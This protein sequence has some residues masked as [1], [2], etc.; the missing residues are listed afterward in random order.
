MAENSSITG[1]IISLNFPGINSEVK[2]AAPKERGNAITIATIVTLTVPTIRGIKEYLGIKLIGCQSLVKKKTL[3][4]ASFLISGLKKM[5][6]DSLAIN[7]NIKITLIMATL[8][9]KDM[10]ISASFS[11]TSVL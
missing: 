1:F 3:K 5:G 2:R 6:K 4:F 10:I 11:L 9:N 7:I 8:A